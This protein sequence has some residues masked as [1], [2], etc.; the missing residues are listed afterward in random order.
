MNEL[1][2]KNEVNPTVKVVVSMNQ[3]EKMEFKQFAGKMN[4][5]F[6]ALVRLAVKN[7]IKSEGGKYVE[8]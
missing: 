4:I 1:F 3:D 7:F 6:S 2:S 5:P 8:K